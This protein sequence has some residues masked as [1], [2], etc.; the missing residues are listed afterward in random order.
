ML[1]Q[2]RR[3]EIRVNP[4]GEEAVLY[5]GEILSLNSCVGGHTLPLHVK[6]ERSMFRL[7]GAT[8]VNRHR[9][10]GLHMV[11]PLDRADVAFAQLGYN[12]IDIHDVGCH[13]GMSEN[14]HRMSQFVGS[15]ER[16]ALANTGSCRVEPGKQEHPTRVLDSPAARQRDDVCSTLTL[17]S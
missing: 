12:G 3:S 1:D 9:D 15:S 5:E 13:R 16:Q 11:G 8:S 7:L 14:T 4:D 2:R 6:R 10:I 17:R